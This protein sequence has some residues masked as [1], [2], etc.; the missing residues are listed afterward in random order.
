MSDGITDMYQ[1]YKY[2]KERTE[3]LELE[4]AIE[5]KV[6]RKTLDLMVKATERE[7]RRLRVECEAWRSGHLKFELYDSGDWVS[8]RYI[9]DHAEFEE[10]YGEDIDAAVDALMA[11]EETP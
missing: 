1:E 6:S 8:K 5:R 9:I 3:A 2:Y 7:N 11:E 10:F 4:L